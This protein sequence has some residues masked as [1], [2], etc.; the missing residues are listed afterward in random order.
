MKPGFKGIE[1]KEG[2]VMIA[3]LIGEVF[4][5]TLVRRGIEEGK[6]GFSFPRDSEIDGFLNKVNELQ[7]KYLD[8]IQKI[9][10]TYGL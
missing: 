4:C 8:K 2:K 9:V 1:A 7:K 5:R 10:S 6:P 3:E